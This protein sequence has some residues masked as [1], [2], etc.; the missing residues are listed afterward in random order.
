MRDVLRLSKTP[1]VLCALT[2]AE[3][4]L[5]AYSTAASAPELFA[6]LHCERCGEADASSDREDLTAL[7]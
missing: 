4:S 2:C 7:I 1:T 5:L 3:R 6:L